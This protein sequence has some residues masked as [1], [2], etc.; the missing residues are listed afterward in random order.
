M[1]TGKV[2]T[3]GLEI[4]KENVLNLRDRREENPAD[5][6][7]LVPEDALFVEP[8]WGLM[9]GCLN[10]DPQSRPRIEKVEE[11][12]SQFPVVPVR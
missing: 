9:K 11:V 3:P 6:V 4:S 10:E 7:A 2:P 5:P 1:F 12:L 8:L